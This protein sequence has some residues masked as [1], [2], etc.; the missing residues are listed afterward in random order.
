MV[1]HAVIKM[2]NSA[3]G[4]LIQST[5][6][7]ESHSVN[8]PPTTGPAE[9]PN[10][11][12]PKIDPSAKPRFDSPT[13]AQAI[14]IIAGQSSAAPTPLQDS[15]AYHRAAAPCHTAEQRRYRKIAMPIRKTFLLP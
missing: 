2:E 4:A 12:V 14:P 15:E 9:L 7:Q 10:E 5:Q 3:I 1:S 6:R 8:A 13:A 11:Q